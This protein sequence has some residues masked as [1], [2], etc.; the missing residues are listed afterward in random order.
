[1]GDILFL[2]L[3]RLRTPLITLILVYAISVGGLVL[4][5]GLDEHG[6]PASLGFF[7]AFYVISYTATTIGFGELPGSFTDAQRAWV[8]L[9]IYLSVTGWAYAVGSIFALVQEP[10][11][12][13]AVARSTFA[14]RVRRLEE[15]FC[16][17]AGY[18]QSGTALAHALDEIGIR[19]VILESRPERAARP[20]VEIYR[21][22]PCCLAADARWPDLLIDAGVRH[23]RCRALIVLVSDDEAAQ[24]I[25]IGAAALNPAL[26]ILARV[27]STLAAGNLEGF[28]NIT[29]I[30]P[31]ATFATNLELALAAPAVLWVE[32]WLTSVPESVC[33]IPP[34]IPR[35]HWLILGYGRFGRSVARAL[36]L[37]GS[38]WTAVD[39][40]PALPDE[41]NLQH[42]DNSVESLASAGIE[43]A[44]GIVACTD[45]D[46]MNL[47]LVT[48]ARKLKPGLHVIIRQNHVAER[49]LIE[50][51][52]ANLC[53][54]KSE[55]MVRECLQLL[56]A[57]LL[58]RFLMQVR[59]HGVKL[60]EQI[61][62]RLLTELEERVPYIW[63]FECDDRQPGLR[64][65]LRGHTEAPLQLGELMISPLDPT[66]P[67]AAVPLFLL[68][69]GDDGEREYMLPSTGMPLQNG[70]R[71]L[72]AGREGVERLQGHFNLDPS[73]LEYVRSGVEPARSWIFRKLAAR[74][75]AQAAR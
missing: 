22:P 34:Q 25:A 28:A 3:R 73:P 74:R 12:R 5:P 4:M 67:L 66:R 57:P 10:V 48:R 18:G 38:T 47:A 71:I 69:T 55:L 26:P 72:F 19:S 35:G 16:V 56:V 49:S 60:A 40:N 52:R 37:T 31:F 23:P 64:D 62:V 68:R 2:A 54:V 42:S 17:I 63:V 6:Q 15:P 53:F 43:R 59:A 46:A 70:D 27:H 44:V 20:D 32:E 11:F 65:V 14:A 45:R 29:A 58:N 39:A 21:D 50:A 30:D 7:H 51:A 61:A 9:S 24:A 36:E 8:T 41:D 1:M 13:N 75:R 33:P